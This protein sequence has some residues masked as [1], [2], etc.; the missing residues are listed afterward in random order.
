[1]WIKINTIDIVKSFVEI[2]SR[3]KKSDIDVI[4]DR[5]VINGKSILGIF[6]LNLVEQVNVNINSEDE[7]TK[8]EFYNEIQKWRI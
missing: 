8:A 1:M 7:N 3:Y 6:S 4:Q 5:Y 2:C